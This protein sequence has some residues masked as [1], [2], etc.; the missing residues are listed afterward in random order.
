MNPLDQL[1]PWPQDFLENLYKKLDIILIWPYNYPHVQADTDVFELLDIPENRINDLRTNP[2]TIFI[3][4]HMFEGYSYKQY[5][6]FKALTDTAIKYNI[7]LH[8]MFY[9]SGNLLQEDC[10]KNWQ[11]EHS[12]NHIINVISW[13]RF[14]TFSPNWVEMF[15]FSIDQTVKQIRNNPNINHFLSLNRVKRPLR[16]MSILKTINSKINDKTIISYDKITTEEVNVYAHDLGVTV[17][18]LHVE[19]L[20]STSPVTLDRS[21][22]E[23]NWVGHP[24]PLYQDTLISIINETLYDDWDNT[25]LFYS[26]K[27]FRTMFS[28]HPIMI[29]GQKGSNTSFPVVGFK[30]YD[31]YFDLSF[32][33]IDNHYNRLTAQI[34][35]LENIHERLLSMSPEQKVNWLLDGVEILN[36]NQRAI[37]EY[38]YTKN[39]MKKFIDACNQL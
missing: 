36:H 34:N 4:N 23:N 8:K 25:S 35:Q 18:P 14:E 10:Y 16:V 1:S 24:I 19:K 32:D 12:P 33:T 15:S 28:N 26:E 20:V 17:D 2:Y 13:N 9:F 30:N 38:A 5:N 37:I 21:D 27:T 29:V 6:C 31:A 3:Y 39:S 7:P 22:F 11:T